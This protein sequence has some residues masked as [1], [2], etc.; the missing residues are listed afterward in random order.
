MNLTRRVLRLRQLFPN[1]GEVLQSDLL[2]WNT[3]PPPGGLQTNAERFYM[4]MDGTAVSNHLEKY[5][6]FY[7]QEYDK[8][9][10]Y[11]G[12]LN[13]PIGISEYGVG[14]SI[15]STRRIIRKDLTR[16][17]YKR[18]NFRHIVMKLG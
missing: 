11:D 12:V 2:A 6:P 7:I 13:R 15:D 8:A 16:L 5:S 9:G 17:K 18:K 4:A 10:F 1:E 14:G 3:Y